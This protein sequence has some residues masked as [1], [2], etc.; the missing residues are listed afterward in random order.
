MFLNWCNADANVDTSSNDLSLNYWCVMTTTTIIIISTAR[1]V[2]C[3][4]PTV[5]FGREGHKRELEPRHV[6]I[7]VTASWSLRP[8]N[9][10]LFATSHLGDGAKLWIHVGRTVVPLKLNNLKSSNLKCQ[11]SSSSSTVTVNDSNMLHIQT[12]DI[13]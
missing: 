1:V 10:D 9:F 12:I 5:L 7:T 4:F 8:V 13:Y 2:W 11:R 6:M 3:I